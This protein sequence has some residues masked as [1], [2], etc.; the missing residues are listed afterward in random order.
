MKRF[1]AFFCGFSFLIGS[2]RAGRCWYSV[3]TW[4]DSWRDSH[5]GFSILFCSCF[6][7]TV[8]MMPS[9]VGGSMAWAQEWPRSRMRTWTLPRRRWASWRSS[10]TCSSDGG[11]AGWAP[12][13]WCYL[14]RL[15][16]YLLSQK[17]TL[18]L[19]KLYLPSALSRKTFVLLKT[20]HVFILDPDEGS[21]LWICKQ[22][23]PVPHPQA[24][25]RQVPPAT[26]IHGSFDTFLNIQG[27]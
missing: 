25:P 11:A 17:K 12:P 27:K 26:S 6:L 23:L 5:L 21:L 14:C 9:T 2:R 24:S 15:Y 19:S 3:E 18:L 22:A 13:Q 20:K 10:T 4:H 16:T 8:L 1:G 7:R